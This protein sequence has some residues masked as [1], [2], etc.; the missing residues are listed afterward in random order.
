M[1]LQLP[2]YMYCPEATRVSVT[3]KYISQ[4]TKELTPWSCTQRRYLRQQKSSW[5]HG[6]GIRGLDHLSSALILWR[7]TAARHVAK[8]PT[9]LLQV[10]D[11]DAGPVEMCLCCL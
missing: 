6:E 2:Q 10:S 7:S 8:P 1:P 5:M 4:S 11:W 3:R 9:L